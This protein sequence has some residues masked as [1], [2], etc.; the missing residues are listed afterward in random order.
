MSPQAKTERAPAGSGRANGMAHY[1]SD[2]R[3][4]GIRFEELLRQTI[5]STPVV[6]CMACEYRR[7]HTDEERRVNHPWA[8][9]GFNGTVWTHPGLDPKGRA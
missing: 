9:H 2:L 4:A 7:L 8:G 3:P 1:Q 6:G 5:R